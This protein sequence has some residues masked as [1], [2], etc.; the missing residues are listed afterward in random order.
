MSGD[1]ESTS[2]IG[3]YGDQDVR[4]GGYGGTFADADDVGGVVV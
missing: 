1:G 4:V 2:D 3:L